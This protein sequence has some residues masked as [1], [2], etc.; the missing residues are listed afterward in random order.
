MAAYRRYYTVQVGCQHP[1]IRYPL[2]EPL[3][4]PSGTR[5]PPRPPLLLMKLR[6]PTPEKGIAFKDVITIT[7]FLTLFLE[8]SKWG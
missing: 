7:Q 5:L 3:S 6:A 4:A 2:D 8:A 1:S